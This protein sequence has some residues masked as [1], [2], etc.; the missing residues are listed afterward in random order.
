MRL[1][2][3]GGGL[4]PVGAKILVKSETRLH[5]AT[6]TT[7]DSLRSQHATNAYFGLGDTAGVEWL[8]VRWVNGT[9]RRIDTPDV[10]R[11]HLVQGR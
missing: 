9:V 3:E 6:I 1:H 11:Y 7:G 2:E 10:D 5:V 4:S 8:E